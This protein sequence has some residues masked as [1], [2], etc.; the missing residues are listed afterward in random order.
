MTA[1][2]LAPPVATGPEP[3]PAASQSLATTSWALMANTVTTSALG[4]LFWVGAT[5]LYS[6]DQVGEDAALV[7][8][9]VLLSSLSQLNLNMG[10][11]RL[12]PQVVHRRGRAVLGTYLVTAAVAVILTSAFL[13]VVPRLSGGLGFL[14]GNIELQAA[15]VA[16][17]VL[18]NIFALQDAVLT[19]ARWAAVVP[20]ENGIFGLLKVGLMVVLAHRFGGHGIFA[21]WVLG[22]VLV[23]VPVNAL[24]FGRVLADR[25]RRDRDPVAGA[26][27]LSD[28]TR[29]GRYLVGDYAAALLSQGSTALLPMLVIGVLGRSDG[30]YFYIAFLIAAAVGALSHS[31]STS[32]V[33]EGAHDESSLADLTRRTARRYLRLVVPGVALLALAAPLVLRPFG[34][35]YSAEG[36]TLLRLLL[37]GTVPQGIVSLYIGVERVRA[38]VG[39]VL[40]IE[41]VAVVAVVGGAVLGMHALG[42]AG[43]GVAF[44]VSEAGLALFVLPRLARVGGR[45]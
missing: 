13:A 37:L 41:A 14:A 5:R 22:M 38:R 34:A 39:R 26:L 44:L 24:I 4:V 29:V 42:L 12:L 9:M 27:T 25:H 30:A 20:V 33:V 43:V 6:P 10:I 36:T 23:V 28:R 35:A 31:L 17:V 21:A 7:S 19:S 18:W 11:A 16:A 2:V 15:L 3:A 45:R 8:A 32:L 40:A 1:T